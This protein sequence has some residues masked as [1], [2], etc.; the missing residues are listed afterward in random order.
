MT[1]S[2]TLGIA[3]IVSALSMAAER[4][5]AQLLDRLKKKVSEPKNAVS[6][7]RSI[8]C[9]VQGVCGTVRQSELF[10]PGSYESIAV[11]VFDGTGRFRDAEHQPSVD[12]RYAA[13]REEQIIESARR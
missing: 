13:A 4:G 3:A 5:D 10:E 2:R 8:R 9:D 7:A 12:A 11:T 1:A 6:D